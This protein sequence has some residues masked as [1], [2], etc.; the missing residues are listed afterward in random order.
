MSKTSEK[1]IICL[2]SCLMMTA[3]RR[4]VD[5]MKKFLL[6]SLTF[7]LTIL[8]LS[9]CSSV[10]NLLEELNAP[11]E[12]NTAHLSP[13]EKYDHESKIYPENNEKADESITVKDIKCTYNNADLMILDIENNTAKNYEITVIGTYYDKNKLALQTETQTFDQL[14]SGA[15][16]FVLFDPGITFETFGYTVE[17]Q[18]T[19]A[20][21][22]INDIE[23]VFSGLQEANWPIDHLADSGDLTPHPSIQSLFGYKNIGKDKSLGIT[24]EGTVVLF[25]ESDE[26]IAVYDMRSCVFNTGKTDYATQQIYYT[27][28]EKL[29]WP[30]AFK[31]EIRP[32]HA[33]T[34]VEPN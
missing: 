10:L 27:L 29:I 30:D 25:N 24:V 7:M 23:F 20:Q 9:A 5:F 19:D 16:H 4:K 31:G 3:K 21:M 2:E 14:A 8:S 13:I 28:E 6:I 34:K 33:T 11:A 17:V 32:L 1:F 12:Q 15:R 26:I 22:Y 18:E